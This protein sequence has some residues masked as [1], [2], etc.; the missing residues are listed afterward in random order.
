MQALAITLDNSLADQVSID[1]AQNN[2]IFE[3]N[4]HRHSRPGSRQRFI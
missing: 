3:T 2:S 1:S 4:D